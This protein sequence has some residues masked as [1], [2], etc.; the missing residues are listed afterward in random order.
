MKKN[1][2]FH[3]L[4]GWKPNICIHFYMIKCLF[5]DQDIPDQAINRAKKPQTQQP[6]PP[7]TQ[8]IDRVLFQVWNNVFRNSLRSR[9]AD[10]KPI[11]FFS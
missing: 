4:P 5:P 8:K 11:S 7:K 9:T 3:S 6:N 10:T 2:L 1:F